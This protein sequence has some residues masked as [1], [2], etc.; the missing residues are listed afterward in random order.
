[1]SDP[2]G[3]SFREIQRIARRILENCDGAK[4]ADGR[5][6]SRNDLSFGRAVALA[7]VALWSPL[8]AAKAVTMLLRHLRSQIPDEAAALARLRGEFPD[9]LETPKPLLPIIG[10][11]GGRLVIESEPT[12]M[13]SK[14]RI[15]FK[16][17]ASLLGFTQKKDG[18]WIMEND[19]DLNRP[20]DCLAALNLA[21]WHILP[22]ATGVWG[23]YLEHFRYKC[24]QKEASRRQEAERV[25]PQGLSDD[26]IKRAMANYNPALYHRRYGNSGR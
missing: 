5:G 7:P 1:M 19:F 22:E 13:T 12:G 18:S 6:F 20:E 8:F 3:D 23:T 21:D 2:H 25:A 15:Q 14:E 10:F 9:T 26:F 11:R 4:T 16:R 24:D 17:K